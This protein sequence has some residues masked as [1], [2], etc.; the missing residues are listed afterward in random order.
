M[1]TPDKFKM[2]S[3]GQKFRIKKAD[4]VFLLLLVSAVGV[5]FYTEK[6]FFLVLTIALG[7]L[8][9]P[10]LIIKL[11]FQWGRTKEMTME[12]ALRKVKHYDTSDWRKSKAIITQIIP[13][14]IITKNGRVAAKMT[15][16][17]VRLENYGDN[18]MVNE[19][20]IFDKIMPIAHF[21][22]FG[23]NTK[24]D[25]L[26]NPSRNTAIFDPENENWHY[27]IRN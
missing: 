24:V 1:A 19:A 4:V 21:Q 26:V 25:V 12:Q 23:I 13:C 2:L 18:P 10:I 8:Y 5:Y 14:D 3:N 27:E 22:S 15:S 17:T 6:Y 7:I 11:L 20:R 9:L 16:F